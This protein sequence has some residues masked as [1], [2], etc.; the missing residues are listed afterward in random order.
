MHFHF[1]QALKK[2]SLALILF[3]LISLVLLTLPFL[4]V[5]T[6]AANLDF[7]VISYLNA[8]GSI[9]STKI[10]PDGSYLLGGSFGLVRV[11]SDGSTI[12]DTETGFTVSDMDGPISGEIFLATDG[13]VSSYV[14]ADSD[15]LAP[16]AGFCSGAVSRLSVSATH[17]ALVTG[18]NTVCVS[19]S[20]SFNITVPGTQINDVLI[21]GSS[22]YVTGY[23]QI[24]GSLQVPY[25]FRY[26]LGGTLQ[27]TAYNTNTGTADSSG[28]RIVQ[29]DDG[30][31]YFLGS[32][33]GGNNIYQLADSNIVNIDQFTNLSGAGA[34]SF[35]Y[36]ARLDALTLA[37]DLSQFAVT[38]LSN[39]NANSLGPND[40]SVDSAG[41]VYLALT[42]SATFKG[43]A[44]ATINGTS[45]GSYA[46]GEGVILKVNSTFT[47][48]DF[49]TSFTASGGSTSSMNSID[50][51]GNTM[52]FGGNTN[53]PIVTV[54]PIASSSQSLFFGII[55]TQQVAVGN[56]PAPQ[57]PVVDPGTGN[58]NSTTSTGVPLVRTGGFDN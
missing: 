27:A 12:I 26:D 16:G 13:G 25:V 24:T 1:T 49:I 48:W 19:T 37:R 56:D 51:E 52:I 7:D 53:G 55:G 41:S 38:R 54:N 14:I 33:D 11:S 23:N 58:N 36:F 28:R 50:V 42:A 39:G 57:D 2:T 45:L 6:L 40:I 8:S 15:V 10:L 17:A 31:I 20:S 44:V 3:S 21:A 32:T 46:G 5:K 9:T 22:I 43:R 47:Q 34:G 35:T 29:G 30:D 4:Q 18:S